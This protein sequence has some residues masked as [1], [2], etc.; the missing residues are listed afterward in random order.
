[1][2]RSIPLLRRPSAGR[3]IHLC[4]ELLEA[5]E[6]PSGTQIAEGNGD[7]GNSPGSARSLTG[8]APFSITGTIRENDV[9]YFAV[10]LAAGRTI[11]LSVA[12][13]SPETSTTTSVRAVAH[14]QAGGGDSVTV[15]DGPN[16][17]SASASA[18]S[19]YINVGANVN[20]LPDDD[21]HA[22]ATA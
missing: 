14:A 2:L 12:A 10:E 7:F 4:A 5:R 20:G 8:T 1:Y 19:D 18:R 13:A 16:P 15:S 11:Q 3:R 22:S 6:L 9:D 21:N 17:T